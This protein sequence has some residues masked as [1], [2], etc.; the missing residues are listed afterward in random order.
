MTP[1]SFLAALVQ[2]FPTSKSG[3]N[4]AILTCKCGA[5]MDW[6]VGS[7]FLRVE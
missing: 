5:V 7:C 4:L 6:Q 1:T 3:C 2:T